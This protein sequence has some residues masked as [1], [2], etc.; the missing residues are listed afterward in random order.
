MKFLKFISIIL[1]LILVNT[2][3]FAEDCES[4]KMDSSVNIIK[5]IK[6][7]AGHDTGYTENSA[8]EEKKIGGW[9]F[10]KKPEWMKKKN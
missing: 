6:C 8:S 10:W 2:S 7:K 4:I 3:S 1:F 9:T 5:K